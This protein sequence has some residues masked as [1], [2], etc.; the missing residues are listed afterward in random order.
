M[1]SKPTLTLLDYYTL[2]VESGNT[3]D[4]SLRWRNTWDIFAT[5]TPQIG[6]PIIDAILNFHLGNLRTDAGLYLATLRNWS[7]GPQP[8]ATRQFIW[9][10]VQSGVAG[11]KTSAGPVGYGG[12]GAGNQSIPGSAVLFAKRIGTQGA[13]VTHMFL[14][15]LLDDQ[16]LAAETG[17]KYVFGS[18]PN[19]TAGKFHAIVTN[20]LA[21]FMGAGLNPRLAAVHVGNHGAGPAFATPILDIV[22]VGPS[23][24][25]QT[26]KNKR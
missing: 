20:R 8:F 10:D 4:P 16:D 19:V 2:I 23:E 25:K 12:E 7:Q 26:R 24:N 6:D 15:G 21:S 18:S 3:S 22:A 5:V 11:L 1:P 14:R 13:K 17:G 9:E